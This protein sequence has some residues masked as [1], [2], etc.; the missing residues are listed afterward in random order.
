MKKLFL[1]L[2]IS[3]LYFEADARLRHVVYDDGLDDF[4]FFHDFQP[5]FGHH[6]NHR[7]IAPKISEAEQKRRSEIQAAKEKLHSINPTVTS[8]ENSVTINIPVD[9]L[10]K[11]NIDVS[12]SH[13]GVV[14]ASIPFKEGKI[15]LAVNK[16]YLEI[17]KHVEIPSSLEATRDNSGETKEIETFKSAFSYSSSYTQS[18][19]AAINVSS[20]QASTKDG[21]LTL[22]FAK[23]KEKK[24]NVKHSNS[25]PV[26]QKLDLDSK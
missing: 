26:N 23:K 7:P 12:I 19:P 11:N 9:N 22:V 15:S 1:G 8:D 25:V 17:V 10:T 18:L 14:V 5:F 2:L 21:I 3:S 6:V 13:D 20:V 24:I 16:Y 4:D